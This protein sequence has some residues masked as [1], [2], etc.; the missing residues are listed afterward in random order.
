MAFVLATP[1]LA[2]AMSGY[3][4]NGEAFVLDTK[5]K[6]YPFAQFYSAL[7]LIHDGWRVRY[8]CVDS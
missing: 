7:Y 8:L 4:Q 5:G 1:T 6:L 2:G 3:D